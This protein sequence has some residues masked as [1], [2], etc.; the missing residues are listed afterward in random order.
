MKNRSVLDKNE[1]AKMNSAWDYFW[2]KISEANRKD[3]I[4][5]S[6]SVKAIYFA[7]ILHSIDNYVFG[8]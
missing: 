7:D 2:G 4:P 6:P 8:K 1:T 5:G 3:G